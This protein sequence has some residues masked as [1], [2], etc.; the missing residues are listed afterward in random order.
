MI[1][2]YVLAALV[3]L[4]AGAVGGSLVVVCLGIRR[5]EAAGSLTIHTSDRLARG[6]RVAT[7]VYAR[8]P[9]VIHEASLHRQEFLPDGQ[10]LE[11]VTR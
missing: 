2:L 9:G 6:A 3:L 5:E 11:V 1:E 10:E 7:G 4:A 8:V